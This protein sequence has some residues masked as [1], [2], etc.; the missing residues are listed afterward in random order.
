MRIVLQAENGF[1][2]GNELSLVTDKMKAMRFASKNEAKSMKR[3]I[4]K[5]LVPRV[6]TLKDKLKVTTVKE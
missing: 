2:L 6:S 3:A 1:Y 4:D 5:V